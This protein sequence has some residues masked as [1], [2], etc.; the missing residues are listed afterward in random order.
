ME[1]ENDEIVGRASR[2]E[3]HTKGLLHREVHIWFYTPRGELLFQ[4]RAKDKDAYPDLLDAT[5]GGHVDAG[6][7][8]SDTAVKEMLEETGVSADIKELCYLRKIKSRTIDAVTGVIVNTFK[9]Q[10]AYLFEGDIS[11]LKIEEGKAVG[12]E[13]WT[14]DR[15]LHMSTDECLRF[16]PKINDREHKEMFREIKNLII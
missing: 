2:K 9:E 14:I 5:V 10:Y 15:V 1:S 16:V 3:A 11:E 7:N 13:A 4:H 8:Y 6:M 12:F